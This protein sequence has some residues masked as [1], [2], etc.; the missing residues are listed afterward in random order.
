MVEAASKAVFKAGKK[1]ITKELLHESRE[2]AKQILLGL[3]A[4]PS[5]FHAVNYCKD[6]LRLNGFT[7]LKETAKWDLEAGKGYYF[8]RNGS[9]ICAFL[10]G[11][12]V[13]EKPVSS[14]KIIGCHTDS[15]VLKVA[16]CSKK[17]T[18]GFHQL[19]VMTYGGGLWRT[20][21][22]RDL[23]LAGKVIVQDGE[24]LRSKYWA[25]GKPLMKVP[26]LAIH[27]DRE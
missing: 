10:S 8:T 22:D 5:H 21:F 13:I 12:Q 27:L 26:S 6:L 20:W 23:T 1:E 4:S 24:T 25:S 14:F 11:T 16:P 19:N 7:E 17:E 18:L 2:Y 9:T 15:P 3:N